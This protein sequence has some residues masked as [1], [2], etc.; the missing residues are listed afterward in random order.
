MT[1]T[2]IKLAK[3]HC[4]YV[5]HSNF[6]ARVAEEQKAGRLDDKTTGETDMPLF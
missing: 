4:A 3:A 5:L 2:L 6:V 1:L